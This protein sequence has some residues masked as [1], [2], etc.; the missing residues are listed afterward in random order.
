MM[1][2]ESDKILDAKSHLSNYLKLD[3]NII[4]KCKKAFQSMDIFSNIK[5][6]FSS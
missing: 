3:L 4:S 2:R 6:N 1:H 5:K